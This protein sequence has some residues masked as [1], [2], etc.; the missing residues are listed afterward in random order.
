MVKF[1]S[2]DKIQAVKRYLEGTEDGKNTTVIVIVNL[3]TKRIHLAL[4][5]VMLTLIS[6]K[7]LHLIKQTYIAM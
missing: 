7:F 5:S 4:Y 3:A 2:K 1:S 6:S